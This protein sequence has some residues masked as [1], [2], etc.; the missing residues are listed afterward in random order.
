MH[1]EPTSF[2]TGELISKIAS[3]LLIL[4]SFGGIFLYFKNNGLPNA[5][6]LDEM[7]PVKKSRKKAVATTSTRAKKR[8]EKE[9]NVATK[10]KTKK[11]SKKKDKK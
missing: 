7:E 2:Y 9:S 3:I 11:K 10:K 4:L 1:F 8:V 6:L 5:A